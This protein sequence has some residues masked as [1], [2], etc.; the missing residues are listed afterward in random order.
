MLDRQQVLA[1]IRQEVLRHEMGTFV[2][3]PPAIAQGGRGIVVVGC[4]FCGVR[5]ETRNEF[6]RHV[7]ERVIA[8]VGR[9]PDTK[10]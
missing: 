2:F 10:V 8:A 9:L 5:I 7:A 4:S 1:A 3:D 6:M